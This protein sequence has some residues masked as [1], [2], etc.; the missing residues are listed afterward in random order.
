MGI[1]RVARS[2]TLQ[3][4]ETAFIESIKALGASPMRI[5]F[6][7]IMPQMLPYAYA[8]LAL[9]VP[10]AILTEAGLSYL[11]LGDPTLP[12]WGQLLRHAVEVAA[13]PNGYW[14]LWVT[15]G[16]LIA[17]VSVAFVFIGHSIDEILNPRIRRL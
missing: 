15:P 8:N 13:V 10:G 11:G 9:G 1:A 17:G 14:W 16:L 6:R 5:M 12:T 7:H 2:I 4:K 3:L